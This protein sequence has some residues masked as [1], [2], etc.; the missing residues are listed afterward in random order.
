MGGIK[1]L[2][3]IV[4]ANIKALE[5]SMSKANSSLATFAG[6]AARIGATLSFGLTAPLT[7][8][9]KTA[10][11]EFLQFEDSIR[12]VGI[13]S[14][15]TQEQ[16]E[17]LSRE[18]K[19]LGMNTE[20][21][22]NEMAKLQL[23]LSK[24]GFSPEAITDIT[25]EITDLASASG[26]ELTLASAITAKSIRA[27]GLE[28]T[29]AAAVTN[30]L[31]QGISKTSLNLQDFSV[32]L[33]FAGAAAKASNVG[34]SETTAMLGTLANN[35]IPASK[36]GTGLR[37]IFSELAKKGITLD[38]ALG[39][40]NRS[41]NQLRTS[42]R[43]FGKTA[44]NQGLILAQN[45]LETA[46]LTTEIDSNKSALKSAAENIRK[47]ATFRFEE[48]KSA[49]NGLMIELGALIS[50]AILP[51]VKGLTNLAKKFQEINPFFQKL[52]L[53][54]S[55]I[56]AAIGPIVLLFGAL[57]GVLATAL[58]VIGMVV[59]KFGLMAAALGLFVITINEIV[60]V[61]KAFF[62]FIKPFFTAVEQRFK[63]AGI[64][65]ANFFNKVFNTTIEKLKKTAKFFGF[66]IFKDFKPIEM[67]QLIKEDPLEFPKSFREAYK[68][69]DDNTTSLIES[70]TSK[71]KSFFKKQNQG[72]VSITGIEKQ[73]QEKRE[74]ALQAH[75]NRLNMLFDIYGA[76]VNE[77]AIILNQS[78]NDFVN[79]TAISATDS[80]ND[81]LFAGEGL[82]KGLT[83]IF[84]QIAIEIGKMIVK[85]A[86]LAIIFSS[87]PKL[88][89]FGDTGE[90][91]FVGILGK[92]LTG[93]ASGGPVSRNTPYIVGERGPELFMPNN[94][95]NIIPNHA[96]G[97]SM[98]PDVRIQGQDLLLI[99]NRASK[100]KN[101]INS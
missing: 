96:M 95:G 8:I 7:A 58:P 31:F 84:K 60:Y 53:F 73:E 79:K 70:L 34:L 61:F 11:T 23:I 87:I 63:N 54:S 35:A 24:Q 50:N 77:Q 9:G 37:T 21:T 48:L 41:N 55:F 3:I 45:R 30:T 42:L 75:Y 17:A 76:K 68:E 20:F 90:T 26:E 89:G 94:S 4:A 18:A 81:V 69:V 65:I 74:L 28:S 71:F 51:L 86:I 22:A 64:R 80:F 57:G 10:V 47:S 13:I 38:Q 49:T 16:F 97:G 82:L 15:S 5:S 43:L 85:A 100:I 101:G 52:I 14:G 12:R 27:F 33:S 67:A 44:A 40:I 56:L 72:A 93:R 19:R 59:L 25:K 2:S 62:S 39:T 78:I 83:N 99:F 46:K 32:G 66:E 88:G 6:N 98:I 36:A 92:L 29:E 1:T 91:G